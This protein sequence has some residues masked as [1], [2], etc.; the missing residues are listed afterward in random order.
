M[1]KMI[2]VTKALLTAG[3]N[4]FELE[5][6]NDENEHFINLTHVDTRVEISF[7]HNGCEWMCSNP[8]A[9]YLF[10]FTD[11]VLEN[12]LQELIS[13]QEA[14]QRLSLRTSLN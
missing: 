14:F 7:K 10:R 9:G 2:C 8:M 1:E 4:K 6:Y 13:K 12:M 11:E 5:Y 3:N